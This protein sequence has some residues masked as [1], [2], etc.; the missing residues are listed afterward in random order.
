MSP[1]SRA[2]DGAGDVHFFETPDDLRAWFAR[3]HETAAEL[4]VG[5]YKAGSGRPSVTWPQVVDEALCVGWIDGIRKGIDDKSYRNRLTPR[6]KG[7]TWSAKNIARVAELE[8]AGRMTA[9]GRR[10]FEARDEARS[11]TYSYEQAAATFEDEAKAAFRANAVAW[12]W[13][14]NAAPSY[15][16]AAI[17]WVGSAKQ[18]ETRAR[19][20]A[21]LI[22]S[23]A[24]GRTIPPLTSPSRSRAGG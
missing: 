20:L 15:R 8:A 1:A 4:W 19:R 10:A 9:A 14:Q 16:K 5:F 11:A 3:H 2:T 6:R 18:A 21:T 17:H 7:S 13:F 23:S 22:D 12:H 24:K